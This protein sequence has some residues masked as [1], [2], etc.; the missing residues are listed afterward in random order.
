MKQLV[1]IDQGSFVFDKDLRT[2]TFSGI[3]I[4]QEQILLITNTTD[5][6]LIYSFADPN[7][8]GILA[9]SVL[10]LDY[11][12][13]SMSNTDRLQIYVDLPDT[14]QLVSDNNVYA[15]SADIAFMIRH[16]ISVMADPVYLNKASNALQTIISSGTITTVSNV[17]TVSSVSN[18]TNIGGKP[19][20]MVTNTLMDISWNN[21]RGVFT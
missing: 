9:G 18:Q 5:Q 11:D 17:A 19:A 21:L 14:V 20:D 4:E 1:G 6:I 2:I 15:T 3:D 12:T 13:T 16:L 10:T 7:I 8:G